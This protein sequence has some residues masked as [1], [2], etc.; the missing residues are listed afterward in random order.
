MFETEMA[1]SRHRQHAR[2]SP[3]GKSK[4]WVRSILFIDPDPKNDALDPTIEVSGPKNKN[5]SNQ[6][7]GLKNGLKLESQMGAE[8]QEKAYCDEEMATVKII[9][10]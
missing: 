4:I 3:A 2:S 6:K 5:I 9:L 10:L 1:G 7:L 8:A